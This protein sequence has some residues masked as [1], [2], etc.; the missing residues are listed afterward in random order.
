[1]ASLPPKE[2]TEAN[3]VT[4][5]GQLPVQ[6]ESFDPKTNTVDGTNLRSGEQITVRLANAD[7]IAALYVNRDRHPT[8]EARRRI[9]NEQI[10]NRPDLR[11]L[12]RKTTPGLE[13]QVLQMQGA[14]KK[15]G[16]EV[17]ARWPRAVTANTE[18]DVA[19]RGEIEFVKVQTE[20]N[21]WRRANVVQPRM[22]Q[23]LTIETLD[24]SLQNMAVGAD[25]TVAEGE[26]SSR[27][28]VTIQDRSD[29]AEAAFLYSPAVGQGSDRR[30]LA[31]ADGP[32]A[33]F[34]NI[35][36][37]P[38]NHRVMAAVA[39]RVDIELE[40]LKGFDRLSDTQREASEIIHDMSRQGQLEVAIT[41]GFSA[42]LLKNLS[43]D[44]IRSETE[45]T[46]TGPLTGRGYYEADMSLRTYEGDG[47]K[48]IDARL[49]EVLETGPL[50]HPENRNFVKRDKDT[51]AA[52]AIQHARD[53]AGGMEAL[54]RPAPS[55]QAEL[56][57]AQAAERKQ[58]AEREQAS[59]LGASGPA[60]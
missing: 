56:E 9:A 46:T 53:N 57:Q 41:P 51:V 4:R 32:D 31:G 39:G 19:V 8:E 14:I 47:D 35:A 6:V 33:A 60:I 55:A 20:R 43:D 27:P 5:M 2:K 44:V 36:M 50:R 16:G 13:G 26:V 58:A 10:A 42:N 21:D 59:S 22:S 30:L 37:S 25:G 28:M 52:A 3:R 23:A 1:M 29:N 24:R 15:P 54:M 48:P 7:E 12:D 45:K 18:L 17:V 40:D 38:Y 49:K 34:Q 11:T